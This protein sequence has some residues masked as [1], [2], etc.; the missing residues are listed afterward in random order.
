MLKSKFVAFE[1][2]ESTS[3]DLKAENDS[4]HE[5]VERLTKDLANFVQGKDNLDKLLSQQR[6][7][8]NKASIGCEEDEKNIYYKDLFDKSK[9]K[10]KQK[11]QEKHKCMLIKRRI[12][13]PR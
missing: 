5:K 7:G 10:I 13:S 3:F 11:I 1:N 9:D 8:F 2:K 12:M 6:C 4:L